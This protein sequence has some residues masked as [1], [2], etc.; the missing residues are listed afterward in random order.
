M[1]VRTHGVRNHEGVKEVA[2]REDALATTRGEVGGATR[3]GEDGLA[4]H[5]SGIIYLTRIC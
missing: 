4:L 3:K 2:T 5:L 1:D